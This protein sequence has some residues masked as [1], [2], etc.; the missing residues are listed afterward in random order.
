MIQS[1]IFFSLYKCSSRTCSI[2]VTLELVR[3]VTSQA[4]PQTCWIWIPDVK[5]WLFGKDP[6]AG[7]DW[8]QR[9]KGTTEDEMVGR[10]HQLDGH[11]FEQVPGVG[12]GQGRLACCSPRGHKVSDMTEWLNWPRAHPL[13]VSCGVTKCLS[14]PG[15]RRPQTE[16]LGHR[17]FSAKMKSHRQI[18]THW[19]PQLSGPLSSQPSPLLRTRPADYLVYT[20]LIDSCPHV[21]MCFGSKVPAVSFTGRRALSNVF[22]TSESPT[23]PLWNETGTYFVWGMTYFMWHT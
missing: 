1:L 20:L 22:N 7:K 4:P 9:E 6:N 19:S 14:L 10:H 17:T 21:R 23:P 15:L 8:R 3:N 11:E 2:D 16:G 5:N 18:R 13:A 12:D